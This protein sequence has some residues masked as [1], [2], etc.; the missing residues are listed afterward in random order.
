VI[1]NAVDSRGHDVVGVRVIV[2]G[3][4]V[5]D[6]LDGRELLLDPGE[7]KFVFEVRGAAPRKQDVLASQGQ[8]NRV[9]RAQF[10]VPLTTDGDA[11]PS[12][13]DRVAQRQEQTT[14]VRG[15]L[16][17]GLLG[18]GG[19]AL[20]AFGLLELVAQ[21]EYRTLR[22]GCGNSRSCTSEELSPAQTKFDLA[23]GA[24]VTGLASLGIGA[25]LLLTR[26]PR[27]GPGVPFPP[28]PS[29]AAT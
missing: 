9:L 2:D 22:D 10:D 26:G 15:I 3:K 20:A 25:V 28:R 19:A 8:K 18:L 27:T 13:V 23:K 12:R 21:D 24:L 29:R 11:E 17:Y 5:R 1:V 14:D 6:R 16:G 7:H 4:V